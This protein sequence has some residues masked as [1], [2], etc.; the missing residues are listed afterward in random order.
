MKLFAFCI[1]G[2]MCLALPQLW[3][4]WVFGWLCVAMFT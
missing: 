1:A 2:L 3:P 4:M